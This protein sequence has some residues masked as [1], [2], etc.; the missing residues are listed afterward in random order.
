MLILGVVTG[1]VAYPEEHDLEITRAFHASLPAE[2][3][4]HLL[5]RVVDELTPLTQ[6]H[7]IEGLEMGVE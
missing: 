1:D 5:C 2:V 4:E 6:R 3:R 7:D